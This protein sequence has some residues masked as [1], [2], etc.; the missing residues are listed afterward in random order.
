MVAGCPPE[1]VRPLI[2]VGPALPAALT[3]ARPTAVV[4]TAFATYALP[5]LGEAYVRRRAQRLG[6][7]G[8]VRETMKLCTVDIDR[9]PADVLEAHFALARRRPQFPWALEAFLGAAGS[10]GRALA[11]RRR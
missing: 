1:Q 7:E 9:I 11:R 8:L 5:G 6:P 4:L 2:R 3:A 10:I